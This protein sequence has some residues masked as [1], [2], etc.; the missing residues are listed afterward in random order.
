[1]RVET[2]QGDVLLLERTRLQPQQQTLGAL[3]LLEGYYY[4]GTFYALCNGTAVEP[5]LTD[6]FSTGHFYKSF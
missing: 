2:T 5:T 3:G 4:L 6:H 1:M